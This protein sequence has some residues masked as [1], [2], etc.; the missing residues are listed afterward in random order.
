MLGNS[1]RIA[2][3]GDIDVGVHYSWILVFLLVAWSLAVGLFPSQFPGISIG[4]YWIM[5]FGASLLLFVSVLI[6]ELAHSFTAE[7]RGLRVSSITLFIFGGV[8]NISG[9]PRSAR[10]ELLIS[11]VGPASSLVLG[12]LLY[13][14]WL[15]LGA[16]GGPVEG[17]VLYLA[18]INILL[19]LFNLIPGFPLDGGRVLRAIVWWVSGSISTAT[20]VA[21]ASGSV[22]AFLFVLGGLFLLFNGA[23]ISGVW[24][25][26]IGWFLRTAAD[27]TGRESQATNWLRGVTVGRVMNPRPATVDPEESLAQLV[28]EHILRR[29]VRA[30]PVVEGERLVGMV[31]LNEVRDIPKEQWETTPVRTVMMR[32]D[33]LRTVPPQQDLTTALRLLAEHDINQL[34]VVEDGR[35][36]GLLSRS[37][38]I[39]YIEVREELGA[40]PEEGEEGGRAA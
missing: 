30:L 4:I 21:V 10:D 27:A 20:R 40:P 25:I 6:H 29:S 18:S 39:R 12:G 11:A 32:V 19:A 31:T 24:L 5:G 28:H 33:D 1:I 2:R 35:L 38:V 22:V 26:L 34:P 3:I 17:V 16:G 14:L 36:V 15:A 7:A 13:V 37:N 8:S 23:F 9:E